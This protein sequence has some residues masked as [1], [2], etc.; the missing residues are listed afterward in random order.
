MKLILHLVF[1]VSKVYSQNSGQGPTTLG[2]MSPGRFSKFN[3]PLL[4]NF[5]VSGPTSINL[6]PH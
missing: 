3:M 1:K 5:Y 4:N 6:I 2:V